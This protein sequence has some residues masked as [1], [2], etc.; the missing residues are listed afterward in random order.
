MPPAAE[1]TDKKLGNKLKK[2]RDLEYGRYSILSTFTQ[3][4]MSN[5][6]T[7]SSNEEPTAAPLWS[8]RLQ[9]AYKQDWKCG[10]V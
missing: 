6:L 8:E 7:N 2:K 1:K 9:P 5:R 4:F 10:K 3:H